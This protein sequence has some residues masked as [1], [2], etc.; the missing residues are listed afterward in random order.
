[1]GKSVAVSFEGDR[2]KIL[3]AS[4]RGKTLSVKKT[5]IVSDDEFD[6]Y[7]Q[8]E[9]SAEFI[10][11]CNFRESYHD[12]LILPSLKSKYL[13][14]IVESEIKKS[15]SRKDFSF[16]YTPLGE[17]VIENKKMLE[18]FYFAVSD[19]EIR[20]VV[21]RF[22]RK[23][24][25]V[26]ALYPS[27][28]SAVS[29]IDAGESV[30]S[31]MGVL[32]IEKERIVFLSK[33]GSVHFIRN[34]DAIDE[35]LADFDIQNINMTINYCFQN[36]RMNPSRVVLMGDLSESSDITMLPTAPLSSLCKTDHIK[37]SVEQFNDF[38][39][40]V[41]SLYATRTSNILSKDLR[42]MYALRTY[43]SH[44]SKVFIIM[45]ILCS[46]VIMHVAGDIGE[47]KDSIELARKN[48]SDINH[49]TSAYRSREDTLR[50]YRQAV[51]FINRKTPDMQ[52]L[53]IALAE[54]D[55][56]GLRFTSIDANIR[57]GDS[58]FVTVRG[59]SFVDT[60]S[61]LQSLLEYLIDRLGKTEGVKMTDNEIDMA[62][63]TFK[64]EL[65]YR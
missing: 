32:G 62:N 33:N 46:G 55:V 26:R 14:K 24:K 18:V 38:I 8:R 29:L 51:A 49:I 56:Q 7:L 22:H 16:I 23:G 21:E 11:T 30:H 41:A 50:Q 65:E 1:L 35:K 52:K 54:L 13:R 27:V 58:F 57:E 34:Y 45:A 5:D 43:M 28:C 9:R 47:T 64:I 42:N 19:E 63:K 48:V 10:V 53:L 6:H 44:A 17:R 61:S 20:N 12:V 25:I 60:Y 4:L 2:V 59:I 36:L 3:H 15:A 37:C 40:P 39:L 31:N